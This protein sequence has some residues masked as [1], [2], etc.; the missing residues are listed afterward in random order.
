M[1]VWFAVVPL[2]STPSCAPPVIFQTL[3]Q[4]SLLYVSD[5]SSC[6]RIP[7]IQLY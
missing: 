1:A 3:F 7:A 2:L 4:S 6:G 5:A